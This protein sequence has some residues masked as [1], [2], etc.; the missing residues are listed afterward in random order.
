MSQAISFIPR[1]DS[2]EQTNARILLSLM[3]IAAACLL[4]DILVATRGLD[5]G[6]DTRTYAEFFLAARDGGLSATRFEPGFVL[7]TRLLGAT[8]MSLVAYQGSLFVILL[9]TAVVATRR[10]YDYLQSD[11]GYLTYL[12]AALMF[13]FL[14][15]MMANGAINAVRQGLAALL[16]FTALLSFYQHRWRSFFLYGVL[17][18]SFH[19]SSLLYLLF[20]PALLLGE[21]KL[22]LLAA[23]AFIAYCTGLT[24]ILVRAAVPAIYNVVMAYDATS[25][26]KAGVRLDFAAFSIFW[27]LLPY[28]VSRLVR[29]PYR[30]RINHSTAVYLV[31]LLPFFAVGWGN[32]SNRYLLPAWMS[33]SL[34]IAA[35]FFHG[36]TTF[37]RNPILL[38][39]GLVVACGVFA[40]YVKTGWVR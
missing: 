16:V 17:A 8:G 4:A 39:V 37:L 15:P 2:A 11:H 18:T 3:L 6:T 1:S 20:A 13:L 29:E 28:L 14:S 9:L 32:Y 40:I 12:T 36:R 5:S 27:Y 38:R 23:V 34:I 19:Y 33:A 30:E 7:V 31:L 25:T 21:R 26:Y 22:R 35:I 10:Y 24:M